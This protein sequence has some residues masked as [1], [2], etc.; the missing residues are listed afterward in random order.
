MAQTGYG[1]VQRGF[2]TDPDIKRVL[3]PE[4]KVLLI[5][6]FTSPHSNMAGLYYCPLSYVADEV[7]L[8]LESVRE[9][10]LG[11]LSRFVTYDEWSDEILVHRA[12]IHQVETGQLKEGDKR[13]KAIEAIL[14][15]AHSRRL[16]RRFLELY[17]DWQFDVPMP[18]PSGA[19][20]EDQEAPSKPL[21]MPL[22]MPLPKP[23]R[24][25]SSYRAVTDAEAYTDAS[26][27]AG[28][29][30]EN[31]AG[32]EQ[33]TDPPEQ[34]APDEPSDADMYALLAPLIRQHVWLGKGPPDDAPKGWG[35]GRDLSIC[36][37]LMRKGGF[38]LTDFAGGL[39]MCR[40]PA[41]GDIVPPSKPITMA[42]F[43]RAGRM[44][45]IQQLVHA[46]RKK[47][48]WGPVNVGRI[49]RAAS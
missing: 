44:D 37:Q 13:R 41:A 30:V 22:G 20:S 26:H 8:P 18:P 33:A 2:W 7:G 4:Q 6:Y 11:P 16:V 32:G 35:M 45:L 29:A 9:W 47:S 10:T 19:P 28:A 31:S 5:Y 1:R 38:S 17:A 27:P 23:L 40:D 36:R 14:H 49:L 46:Y 42:Y 25:H 24:S 43:N 34:P 39:S 48:D 15:G 21:G 3:T 12:L